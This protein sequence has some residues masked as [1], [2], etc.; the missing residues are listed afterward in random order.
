MFQ[1]DP[2]L[3]FAIFLFSSTPFQEVAKFLKLNLFLKK[4]LRPIFKTT[5]LFHSSLCYQILLNGLLMTKQRSF[6]VRTNFYTSFS[7][8]FKKN[9]ST[10][11]FLGHL[12]VEISTGFEKGL[13]TGMILIDSQKAFDTIDHQILLKEMKYLGFP[14]N[15]VTCFKAISVNGNSK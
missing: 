1:L 5:A 12:T 13:L 11:T 9:Y 7:W 10:N 14:K 8:V 3:N 2:Y 4:T 15:T 6:W